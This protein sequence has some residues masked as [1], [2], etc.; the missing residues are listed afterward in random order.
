MAKRIHDQR[1]DKR[2]MTCPACKKGECNRCIDVSLVLAGRPLIC[3]CTRKNHDGEPRDKQVLDPISEATVIGPGMMI[4]LD[5]NVEIRRTRIV[6]E[7]D[8]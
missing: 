8:E 4:D 3:T 5:G 7:S 6:G 2:S 1:P